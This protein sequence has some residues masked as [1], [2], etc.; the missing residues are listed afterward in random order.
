[1]EGGGGGG[2]CDGG[3]GV[4]LGV[5][6]GGVGGAKLPHSHSTPAGVDG[7]GSRTPPATPKKAGKMLAVRVQ[8]LDDT[9]TMFQVQAKALGRVLFDQV[10]KQL[11]LLEADYFGLEYQDANTT[12]YWLDLEKPLSRQVG[13]S[14]VDPLLRFCVKFY[15]PDPAQLEEEFTRYLYCLQIKRDLAQGLLQCN[16]NT[17]A[18]MASYI[19]QAECGDYVVEDYPD[20]TYLSTYKFV[21][22]QDP[23][24]ERRIME[25]HKKHA[26]QSP[27]EADLNLLET[28]RR[29]ELY[30]MKMHPAKDHEGVPLN[31]AVAHMGI[32]VFQNFTKINTFSWAKIRKIS[33]KRKRFLIKLHP[34]GYGYYKDTVEFFFEGRNE[35]KNFWK[36]CVENHGFFRCSSVKRVP[37]QKTRV[38]SRGSSFR[39]SGRTQKQIV[40]FVREN[41]VKRQTFQRSQSFRHSSSVHSSVVNV[42]TSL[43]AHPLLPL[44]DNAVAGTP[45]S[46]S[47]G[48]M[49]LGSTD[50]RRRTPSMTATS[51]PT[52]TADIHDFDTR[53]FVIA[54]TLTPSPPLTT[55]LSPGT[56]VTSSPQHFYP[57]TPGQQNAT[58]DEEQEF[59]NAQQQP[60]PQSPY[61]HPNTGLEV[62]ENVTPNEG[63]KGHPFLAASTPNHSARNNG[64]ISTNHIVKGDNNIKSPDVSPVKNMKDETP[65]QKQTADGEV[66]VRKKRFP[67]D[68]AY[69]IAKELLMTERT[70]RKDLEVINLWFRDEVT[71]EE[72]EM[73]D[74]VVNLLL[75]LVEPL[76]EAH[77]ALLREVE[78]RLATWEGRGNAHLKGDYQRIGDVFLKHMSV[79]PLYDEY[80]A[81]HL[82]VLHQLDAAFRRNKKF[83]QLYRDFELQKVCYLPLT[84]FI[85]KPLQRLLHYQNLLD[86]LIRHYGKDHLDYEDCCVAKQKLSAT[87]QKV[88]AALKHSENFVQLCELQRDLSGFDNLVQPEREFLRQGCLMKQS[89]K[90]YQQRMFFLFSDILLYTNRSVVPSIQFRVHGQMP[91]RGVM[92]E[93]SPENKMG[94]NYCFTIYGGNRALTVAAGSQEEKDKWI[95]DLT[96]AIQAA[97]ER[98]DNKLQYLSLKSCSSSDEI[99]D[100]CGED[101][102]S[103]REKASQTQ[104]SNTTVHVCWHRNTSISMQ[105]QLRA[106]ENQLSGYLLRKFKN[107]NGWQKLWVVFTNFCL[108]FYKTYQDD[109]PLASLPLLGYTVSTPS[110]KDGIQKDYVFKLQFK[111]HVYFFRAESEYTFGRWME[112]ISS[113]TQH[114]GRIRL[115]SRKDSALEDSHR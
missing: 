53:D 94:A 107:S 3:V 105:D 78:Q 46:L 41:Y 81:M 102:A 63:K 110:E 42:G 79:L 18:L 35:C 83:E 73:P 23:E 32:V 31:L 11:H 64:D 72:E 15:T 10:C 34:E 88:P 48:S 85:L 100:K 95:E 14:L 75:G 104:R 54:P 111:N 99:I 55:S 66:E 90:G 38:L 61:R 98:G 19:V 21:P 28:S 101:T 37:R 92:V 106:V 16:D 27:A 49:T 108:F 65:N 86:R 67:I 96:V 71:K 70:Y 87:A 84:A 62:L 59:V 103:N 60:H 2:S 57:R 45:A 91:L 4:G 76:H 7:G 58:D 51:S 6:G 68:R 5:S 80:L 97:K 17:A 12:K 26:G 114:S 24:L 77:T 115:F 109:F 112:V 9:V 1:M 93:E 40:E 50:P 74:E 39:Y 33:F 20:H 69:F 113:A 56:S 44:G 8:M 47:C 13:L 43:S 82:M 30:G 22:N 25:N 29:C 36:K 52:H 89:R